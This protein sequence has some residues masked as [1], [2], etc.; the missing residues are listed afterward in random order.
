MELSI[1]ASLSQRRRFDVRTQCSVIVKMN[2]GQLLTPHFLAY[3]SFA[4][5]GVSSAMM[6]ARMAN[7]QS[8]FA[9]IEQ[10]GMLLRSIIKQLF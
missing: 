4:R 1:I 8:T 3:T 7:Q 2:F 9:A 10:C 5:A 6:T